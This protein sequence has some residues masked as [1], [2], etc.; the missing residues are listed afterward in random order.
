MNKISK[1]I[2][3][4]DFLRGFALLGIILV[5]SISIIQLGLPELSS[6]ITYKKFLDFFIESKFFSIFSY[7]FGIG[8]YIFMQ[9][10]EDKLENKYYLYLRRILVLGI[11]GFCICNY[12]LEKH[13]LYIQSSD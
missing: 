12:S 2:E 13:C 9:R 3:T 10:A 1:R 11:F 8:F 6:D 4:L 5:N 7:L